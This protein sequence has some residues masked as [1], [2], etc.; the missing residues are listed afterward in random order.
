[1]TAQ[2]SIDSEAIPPI[3]VGSIGASLDRPRFTW[4]YENKI[5]GQGRV[6]LPSKWRPE[7]P[8]GVS[9]MAV[10]ITHP[11][12]AEFVMVLPMEQ[13]YRFSQG[14]CDGDFTQ[15]R[16]LAERHDY[17]DRI[18]ELELDNN[19]R[20]TLPDEILSAAKLEGSILFVGCIDRF[21]IWNPKA[22]ETARALERVSKHY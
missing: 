22:Y 13:F 16:K 4:R 21:E 3:T 9:F 5:D 19:G 17:V 12:Q 15:P 2:K 20:I 7:S 14:I 18:I 8:K 11:T 1:M 6:P 10:M